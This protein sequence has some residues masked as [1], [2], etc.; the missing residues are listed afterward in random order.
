ML[1]YR[2]CLLYCFVILASCNDLKKIS[3]PPAN[4]IS[5][6]KLLGKY[7]IPYN[8]QYNKT[9]VGGLSGID[10]DIKN[11]QY[12]LISDDRSD[13]NPARFYTAKIF[14]TPKGID[15]I[16]FV[17]VASLLQKGN[18]I[19][20]NKKTDRFHVPDPEAIRYNPIK[21]ELVWSSEGERIVKEND[22]VLINPSI[23]TI[24][25]GGAFKNNFELPDNL[26]MHVTEKGPRQNGVLEGI[27]FA[28]NYRSLFVNVEEPL[29][30]D[31]PRADLTDNNAYIRIL[32][33]DVASKKNIAQYGYKLEPV[34]YPP[35][36]ATA[37]KINGVPDILNIGEN[38]FLVIERS[39][40]TGRLACT[41]RVFITSLDGA[42]DIKNTGSLKNNPNFKP[43]TKKLLL[44]MDDLGIYIDNIEGMTFGP[45]LPNG[46]KTLL[47]VADNNFD[48]KEKAQLLLFE[49]IE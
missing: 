29:Y 23:I 12:Y 42:T 21:K 28:D 47:F 40:S 7:E 8:L 30:E 34:A 37:F 31:G 16:R 39:F 24:S 10:Y 14:I 9:T 43:A 20:P 22:T 19:Y 17:N 26:I 38:K 6:I 46:H 18:I 2:I 45:M 41:I 4:N 36:P 13:I 5:A 35:T 33:F 11:D 32:K 3:Q 15:S 1:R 44:N 25:R 27:S 48:V 49:V